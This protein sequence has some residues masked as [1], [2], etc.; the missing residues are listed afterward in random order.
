MVKREQEQYIV[1]VKINLVEKYLCLVK[2]FSSDPKLREDHA[3]LCEK[4]HKNRSLISGGK[5]QKFEGQ[6]IW[7]EISHYL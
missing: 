4:F 3:I 6:R 1:S 5:V 7:E 2:L